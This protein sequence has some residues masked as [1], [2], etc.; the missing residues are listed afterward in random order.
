MKFPKLKHT[1]LCETLLYLPMFLSFSCFIAAIFWRGYEELLVCMGIALSIVF[2]VCFVRNFSFLV[3]TDIVFFTI[4]A[5]KKDRLWY[6]SDCNGSD[7]KTAEQVI[8]RRLSHR[9]REVRD[10]L[11]VPQPLCMR[12][13]HRYSWTIHWKTFERFYTLYSVEYLD[14]DGYRAIMRAAAANAKFPPRRTPIDRQQRNAP[15]AVAG[16]VIILADRIAEDI[17]AILRKQHTYE[18]RCHLACV[19]DFSVGRY[20]FDGMA[21]PYIVGM[22]KKPM[23][24]QALACLR[25]AVFGGKLPLSGNSHRAPFLN[26]G[27]GR[28]ISLDMS[29][30]EYIHY[31]RIIAKRDI[32]R[33]KAI[34]KR[35]WDGEVLLKH[36]VIYC[37]L[38]GRALALRTENCGADSEYLGEGAIAVLMSDYWE[39]PCRSAISGKDKKELRRRIREYLLTQ[40]FE[41]VEFR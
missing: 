5:W 19:A 29:L 2:I 28:G 12:H 34:Y 9:G 25:R 30:W 4:R 16:G 21:E 8:M 3:F 36:S 20:Y 33:N 6:E 41:R 23:K 31:F 38:D 27:L 14:A 18:N 11:V 39:Y 26:K 24:N 37:C 40:G 7:R 17:P 22:E 1:W 35:L 13:E 32:G 15:V 10:T